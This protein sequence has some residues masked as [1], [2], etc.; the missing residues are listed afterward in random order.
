MGQPP[1]DRV[2]MLVHACSDMEV[3][4]REKFLAAQCSDDAELRREV[5]A[6][7]AE[8]S[9]ATGFHLVAGNLGKALPSH[10]RLIKLLGSGGM[11]EVYLAHDT[12]LGRRV[13]IK[14]LNETLKKDPD[15][16]RRF[17]LE[18]RSASALNH[19]N[20]L[21]IFDI[22]ESDGVQYIVSEHVDGETLGTRLARGPLPVRACVDIAIQI[23]SALAA[24]HKAGIVHRDLK[25]DNIMI[26]D[27]GTVKVVDFGLAK[28][29]GNAISIGDSETLEAVTTSPGMILGTPGYMSPEQTRGVPLDGRSD[30]FSLGIIIFE[31]LTGHSPFGSGS[32]V[33]MIAAIIMKE[34]RRVEDL[35]P[36]APAELVRIIDK[37]LQKDRD[38]RYLSMNELLSDL[39]G[40]RHDLIIVTGNGKRPDTLGHTSPTVTQRIRP[41]RALNYVLLA[42]GAIAVLGA[43]WLI[44]KSGKEGAVAVAPMRNVP[45]TSWS[46]VSA[47][48]IAAASFSPDARMVAFVSKKSGPTEVWV[49]SVSGGDPI[50]VTKNGFENQYPVW[51]PDREQIAFFSMRGESRGI[52]RVS[53][54]GGSEAQIVEGATA[55][56][57]RWS[58]DGKIYYQ[59]GSDLFAVNTSSGEREQLTDL[60][61]GGVRPRTITI[62][63]D[64]S[65][66]AFS[67][68][69]NATWKIKT[70]RLDAKD[71][72]DVASSTDQIDNIVFHP[73]GRSIYYTSS[74]AGSVQVFRVG[75]GQEAPVQVS[76]GSNDFYLQD[77]SSDGSKLLYSSV[78][79]TSD[80][81]LVNTQDG[82]ESVIAN[83]VEEEY[84]PDLSPNG[85]LATYQSA[86]QPD[87]PFGSS[88]FVR[89]IAEASP[90][91]L[92]SPDGFSPT[93]SND[94]QW[95]AY[96]RRT[97][98]GMSIWKVRANGAESITLA[99][100]AV[101]AVSYR[102][103][104]YL[105]IGANHISWAPD[106]SEVAYSAQTDG[107]SNIW[108]VS[109]DGTQRRQLSANTDPRDFYCCTAWS[110]DGRNLAYLSEMNSAP[111]AYRLWF[112]AS[113]GEGTRVVFT[114][115]ERFLFLGLNSAGEG[116]IAQNADQSDLSAT[117]AATQLYLI[118]STGGTP[119]KFA[120]LTNAYFHNIHLSGNGQTIAFVSR[121][122]DTNEL[123]TMPATGGA[124]R[125]IVLEKDPKVMFSS[126]AVSAD[127]R[128]IAFGKQTRTNLLSML[129]N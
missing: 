68:K 99:D 111:K 112:A 88:V 27:D 108:I 91:V 60:A 13:A 101:G 70:K 73:N 44:A 83:D 103:T 28:A 117:P 51:S 122:N 109:A 113:T 72:T 106:N 42:G 90:P 61:A 40:V 120:T 49:K 118:P 62:S 22:G 36:D 46:S 84:W 2:M 125:R 79:E 17:D 20:I 5:E 77:V 94:G 75:P 119:R 114:S 128:S 7:L 3:E 129:T 6:L 37:T 35:V 8:D 116:I 97:A 34:P 102:A 31:M 89:S 24:A 107:I 126:L 16:M 38:K 64:R 33:D 123:W 92:V 19:P 54:T 23:A 50:Q 52:W 26:R 87:R 48:A 12:R 78:T 47:E 86:P 96:F 85:K 58:D 115:N 57:I 69:E 93:W 39:E 95:V 121:A 1:Y 100:G 124:P 82:R 10:Y 4:E 65:A 11:A 21:T 9:P 53:F 105:K 104:P 74:A 25:P 71:F 41:R 30:I 80:L 14:F 32:V 76:S 56:L 67:I 66:F 127:G 43:A 81:W 55:R 110:S 98:T 63:P 15:R 45:I 18:A 59:Q 29:S